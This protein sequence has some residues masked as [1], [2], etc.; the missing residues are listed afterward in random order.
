MNSIFDI[1]KIGIAPSSS[2]TM[3]PMS[4]CNKII[5]RLIKHNLLKRVDA[6]IPNTESLDFLTF[7]TASKKVVF[8]ISWIPLYPPPLTNLDPIIT[9]F[10]SVERLL[11]PKGKDTGKYEST[12]IRNN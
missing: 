6:T 11:T 10:R 4:A 12:R 5:N 3:G 7:C 2:H 9:E 1:F 8:P